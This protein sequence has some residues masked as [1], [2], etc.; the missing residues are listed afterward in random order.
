METHFKSSLMFKDWNLKKLPS[1][2]KSHG[3]VEWLIN[4]ISNIRSTK[5]D[6]NVSPGSFIDISIR[7]LSAE[8]KKIINQNLNLFQRVGRVSNINYLKMNGKGV[9][10]VVDKE[11]ITLYFSQ[12]FDLIEQKQK[13]DTKVKDL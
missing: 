2:N 13:I 5:V 10:I 8:K 7:E 6:L 3:K 9:K 12:D 4:L 11:T 1:Y